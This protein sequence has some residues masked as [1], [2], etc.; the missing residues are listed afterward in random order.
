MTKA[1]LRQLLCKISCRYINFMSPNIRTLLLFEIHFLPLCAP[2]RWCVCFVRVGP[3]LFP[4]A[5]GFFVR[6][7][8]VLLPPDLSALLALLSC[9]LTFAKQSDFDFFKLSFES[10]LF[11]SVCV[12]WNKV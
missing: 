9:V 7:R 4:H 3:V 12:L 8:S 5:V 10:E 11:F 2:A 6:L 1:E